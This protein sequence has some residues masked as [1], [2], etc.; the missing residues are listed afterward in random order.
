VQIACHGFAHVFNDDG[1]ELEL[2]LRPPLETS[3]DEA[4]VEAERLRAGSGS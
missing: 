1:L 2:V 3:C 4:Q